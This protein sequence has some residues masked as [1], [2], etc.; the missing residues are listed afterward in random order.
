MPSGHPFLSQHLALETSAGGEIAV[1]RFR[2]MALRSGY[3]PI[4]DVSVQGVTQSLSSAPESADRF[5]DE[6]GFQAITLRTDG[7]PFDPFDSIADDQE[8]VAIDRMS[9]ALHSMNFFGC[10]TARTAVSARA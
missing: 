9:R 6:L 3:E 4:F 7:T 10:A 5:G 8:L 2:G 1:A